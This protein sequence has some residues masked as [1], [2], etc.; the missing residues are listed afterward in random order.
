MDRS[1]IAWLQR[2]ENEIHDDKIA[3]AKTATRLEDI[4][5]ALSKIASC[6]KEIKYEKEVSASNLCGSRWVNMDQKTTKK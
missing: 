5:I 6:L 3:L 1:D 2:I 4:A